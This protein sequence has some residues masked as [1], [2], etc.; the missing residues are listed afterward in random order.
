MEVAIE[1]T[2]SWYCLYDQWEE[3]GFD[4]EMIGQP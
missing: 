2:P 3:E 4:V 1:A